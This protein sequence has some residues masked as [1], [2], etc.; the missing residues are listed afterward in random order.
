MTTKTSVSPEE[1]RLR[2]LGT[3]AL[4][5]VTFWYR[6]GHFQSEEQARGA[7]ELAHQQAMDGMGESKA[8][9]MGLTEEEYARWM[10]NGELP[11]K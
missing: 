5:T 4:S 8:G 2:R 9:W 10:R 7:F 1:L 3:P 6:K 11:P